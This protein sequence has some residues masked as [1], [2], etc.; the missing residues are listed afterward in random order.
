ML[1]VTRPF[2]L[3]PR[4]KHPMATA[5]DPVRI[6]II[7]CG[8]IAQHHLATYAEIPQAKVIAC[9]DI[10]PSAADTSAA[11]FQIPN[12]YYTA[13]EMLQRDDLDA[14]DVCVHNNLHM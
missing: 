13:Q 5:P 10:D 14:I 7:G 8:Q 11:K 3:H 1:I 2:N 9:A 6:G 4:R 12:I